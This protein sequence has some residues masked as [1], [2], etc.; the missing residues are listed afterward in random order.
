MTDFDVERRV[1][2]DRLERL[3]DAGSE[4][5]LRAP[6]PGH[7]PDV[8]QRRIE[9]AAEL[10]DRRALVVGR[11]SL[12]EQAHVDPDADEPLLGAVMEVALDALPLEVHRV[13]RPDARRAQITLERDGS[14]AR[15]R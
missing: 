5:E 10:L 9:I 2:R 14:R 4:E 7:A 11:R 8:R 15:A 12:G 3:G 1:G 13:E 6:V